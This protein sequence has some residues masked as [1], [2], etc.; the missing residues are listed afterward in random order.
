MKAIYRSKSCPNGSYVIVGNTD[1]YR[2]AFEI[3]LTKTDGAGK[4]KE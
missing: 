4:A 3:A 1:K 2:R